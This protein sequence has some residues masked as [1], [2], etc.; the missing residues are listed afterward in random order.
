MTIFTGRAGTL[1]APSR[2]DDYYS[3]VDKVAYL[4]LFVMTVSRNG[5]NG[6]KSASTAVWMLII[7]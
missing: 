1:L 4:R 5:E 6:I 3:R 7:R 2:W